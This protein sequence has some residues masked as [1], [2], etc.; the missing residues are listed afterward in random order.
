MDVKS[1][2]KSVIETKSFCN[3]IESFYFISPSTVIKLYQILRDKIK[4]K[5]HS[6]WLKNPLGNDIG[7]KGYCVVEIEESKIIGNSKKFYG[8]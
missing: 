2:L 7:P 1:I 8:C 6:N 4:N 5:M 3:D